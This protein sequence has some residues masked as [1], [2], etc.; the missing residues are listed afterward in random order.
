MSQINGFFFI[1]QISYLLRLLLL[2]KKLDKQERFLAYGVIFYLLIGL[3]V[4]VALFVVGESIFSL[5]SFLS[6]S[7]L[8]VISLLFLTGIN[9]KLWQNEKDKTLY[10]TQLNHLQQQQNR[11][12]ED[13]VAKRTHEL[14]SRNKHIELLMNEL[15]H[16][17]KNNLQLLYSLNA[18]QL[19]ESKD[20]HSINVLKDN[21]SRIKAMMLVNESLNPDSNI[22]RKT[23]SAV[24]FITNIVE[25]SQKMFARSEPVDINMQIADNIILDATT[26]VCLGLIVTELITNSYKHAFANQPTPKINIKI[27]RTD[28]QWQMRYS[29]N[30]QGLN[31]T[32]GHRFGLSLIADLTRQLK[33]QYGVRQDNGVQYFFIFPNQL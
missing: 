18:L 1:I 3:F 4:T 28:K 21:V 6:G 22:D 30:G 33:G 2:W 23:I 10:L 12:L 31:N 25:H 11:L 20:P 7:L 16:R 27:Q 14:N 13:S 5:F 24:N 8:V 19:I 32:P 17:V 29:D 15:N 9:G 26:G